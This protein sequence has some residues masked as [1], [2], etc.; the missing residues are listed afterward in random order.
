MKLSIVTTLYKSEKFI[1]TFLEQAIHAGDAFGGDFEIIVVDD[2]SP[3]RARQLAEAHADR[4]ARISV[5]E[6]TRNF[7]HHAAFWCGMQHAQGDFCFLIDSDLEINPTVL[8]DFQKKMAA[9]DA[10]V[11]YGVQDTRQGGIETRLLGGIF[12]RLFNMMS[13]AKVPPD[14]MTERLMKKTVLNAVLSMGDKN[15]FLGGMFHWPGFCQV[16]LL[17]T[18]KP[19]RAEASYSFFRRAKLLVEAITSFSSAPLSTVFWCGIL[20]SSCSALYAVYLLFR[21]LLFPELVLDGF[22]F[23]A[24]MSVANLGVMMAAFGILGIYV[25]KMFRQVQA[26]PLFIVKKIHSRAE[27]K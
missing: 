25:H 18:K 17:L 4:D 27:K 6:L 14:I 21:R 3:D 20:L 19:Q 2:G 13:D 11:V 1:E 5:I 7:G 24:L 10:D 23:L 15:L 26:R 22:T 16:P 12:W 8:K 9:S